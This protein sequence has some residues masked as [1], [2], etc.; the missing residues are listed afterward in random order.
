M[1]N[2]Y[3]DWSMSIN[4]NKRSFRAT[5]GSASRGRAFWVGLITVLSLVFMGLFI[6]DALLTALQNAISVNTF[7]TN[8]TFQLYNP[9]RRIAEG[10]IAGYDFPFFHGI[11]VPWLH[12]P[13]FITLGENLFA[14]EF[15]K[16]FVSP[17]IFLASTFVLFYAYFRKFSKSLVAT[18]LFT[19]IAIAFIPVIE[20]GG[21]LRGLRGAFP[22]FVAAA[23]IWQTKKKI[24]YKRYTFFANDL[25]G[26]ALVGLSFAFGTE[27]G[28]ASGLAYLILKSLLLWRKYKLSWTALIEICL[29]AFIVLVCAVGFIG[30]FSGGHVAETLHYALIDV[31]SDQ[32]WYFGSPPNPFITWDTLLP[33]TFNINLLP[34][35]LIIL[36]GILI[37]HMANRLGRHKLVILGIFIILEGLIVYMGTLSGYYIPG[38]QLAPLVRGAGMVVVIAVVGLLFS[39]PNSYLKFIHGKKEYTVRILSILLVLVAG[40]ILV[41]SYR[42]LSAVREKPIHHIITTSLEA[43]KQDDYFAASPEWK[44]RLD[45]FDKFIGKDDKIWSTYTGVY[46]STHKQLGLA[47]G[48][49]DYII[50]ALGKERRKRYLDDFMDQRPKFVTTLIPSFFYYEEWLWSTSADFYIHLIK[51]YRVVAS[52]DSHYLWELLEQPI[53]Q[54]SDW[55]HATLSNNGYYVLPANTTDGVEIY[56]V[57]INYDIPT[58]GPL[59]RIPRYL[60]QYEGISSVQYPVSLPSYTNRVT[61]VVAIM[62]G[63]NN[64]SLR[65]TAEGLVPIKNFSVNSVRYKLVTTQAVNTTLFINNQCSIRHLDTRDL[66]CSTLR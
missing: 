55:K 18:A 39:T 48:G 9:L 38:V 49:E 20:P 5:I 28:I 36:S 45:T 17:I 30:L 3:T 16:W 15:A 10:Q 47:A 42:L 29:H 54:Q 44:Q 46:E 58:L 43:R 21:S 19:C 50:H 8:G 27:H 61:Q 63:D 24:G 56:E 1:K 62:P 7:P 22:V 51:N 34:Y 23:L 11:G 37:T 65:S 32:G 60:I 2:L 25:I 4:F 13:A 66:A 12:M 6:V 40:V 59:K 33:T 31:P 53:Q 52:N 41:N 35:W 57:E 26:M 64:P 14:A